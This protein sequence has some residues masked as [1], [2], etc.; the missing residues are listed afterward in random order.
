MEKK[1][2]KI[3][4]LSGR[5]PYSFANLVYDM[6]T[7]MEFAGHEVDSLTLY[8]FKGQKKNMYSI[9]PRYFDTKI[10]RA[11]C[12]LLKFLTKKHRKYFEGVINDDYDIVGGGHVIVN[13]DESKPPVDPQLILSRINKSYDL[14]ITTIWQDM[15]T[16]ETLR[17]LYNKLKCPIIIMPADMFPMTGGCY[18][19]G[20]CKQYQK[21]CGCCPVFDSHNPDDLTHINYLYKKKVYDTIS[22]ALLSNS[23][24]LNLA[25]KSNLFDNVL[26]KFKSYIL[27]ENVYY[28]HNR[29]VCKHELGISSEKKFI[30]MSRSVPLDDY[31]KGMDLMIAAVNQFC[32]GKSKKE[33]D[34]ILI[35]LVGSDLS[36]IVDRFPVEVKNLGYVNTEILIK[37][38]SA[39]SLFMSSSIDDAGP[40]MVNQSIMCG[41]PVVSFHIG[42]AIDVIK[43][44]ENGYRAALG[45]VED[46]ANGLEYIFHL[47]DND[48]AVMRQT[49]REIAMRYNSMHANAEIIESTYWELV[50][51]KNNK[52]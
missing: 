40:S 42:T 22:C 5:N 14:V 52:C 29:E 36:G 23:Y 47:N 4:V 12:F 11:C 3:L 8:G 43:Q 20:K 51:R 24:I 41:T 25:S 46:F 26:M 28:P 37:S 1:K 10:G 9:Y 38:Y 35:L 49:T 31:R 45:D 2:I 44:K 6:M 7:A 34:S 50:E 48:Y 19:V 13:S 18:Y 15:I 16:A 21:G 39:S 32:I 33:L 30:M 17:C 27:N